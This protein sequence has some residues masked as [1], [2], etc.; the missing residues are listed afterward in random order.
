MH[1]AKNPK[2]KMSKFFINKYEPTP[3][4]SGCRTQIS[5]KAGNERPSI[6]KHS[7]PT[8]D[9]KLPRSGIARAMRTVEKLEI[10]NSSLKDYKDKLT[11][12]N[13]NTTA[14]SK[15]PPGAVR[16]ISVH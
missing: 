7:A 12:H 10:Q 16:G 14:H 6:D 5:I 9:V 15:F 3:Y 1:I 8:R 2:A 11:S 13:N 4:S